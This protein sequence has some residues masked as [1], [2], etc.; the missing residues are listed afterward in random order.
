[1]ACHKP[2]RKEEKLVGKIHYF[3]GNTR[4]DLKTCVSLRHVDSSL[5]PFWSCYHSLPSYNLTSRDHLQPLLGVQISHSQA[6]QYR[7]DG[8]DFH[9]ES[10]PS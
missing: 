4:R 2:A 8:D 7:T 5:P 10:N 1:M 6:F 9:S 3:R